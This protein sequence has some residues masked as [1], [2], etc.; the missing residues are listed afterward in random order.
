MQT[1]S[2]DQWVEWAAHNL[3]L[4]VAKSKVL[5]EMVRGGLPDRQAHAVVNEVLTSAIFWATKRIGG[6][7]KK[8]TVLSDALL[9]LESRSFDPA[10]VPRV[11]NLSSAAFLRDYYALN[12]PVIIEDVVEHW[13]ARTKWNLDFFR[14]HYGKETVTYQKGRS[15]IDYRDSFIDHGVSGLFSDYINLIASGKATN[16]YYLIAHDRLL[17]RP[18]FAPL[19]GDIGFDHRYFDGVNTHARVFFWLGPKG[20]VTPLHRDLGNVYLA[21]ILGRKSIKLIPS[22]QMHRVYNSVGYHSDVDFENYSLQ[23]YPLLRDACIAEVT[24]NPG[25]LLFIPL[26]WWHHVKALDIS[27]TVTGNNFCFNNAFTPIF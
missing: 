12:R 17:D 9:E 3:A 18:S 4:G 20:S 2:R 7:L 11:K 1:T 8:W 21:Q 14:K 24:V 19:L 15:D 10:S 26:G 23:D 5:D 16:D 22:K 13:P 27:V 25:D 6:D